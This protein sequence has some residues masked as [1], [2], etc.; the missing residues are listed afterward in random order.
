MAPSTIYL[1]SEHLNIHPSKNPCPRKG[2]LATVPRAALPPVSTSMRHIPGTSTLLVWGLVLWSPCLHTTLGC[3]TMVRAGLRN[4]TNFLESR[5]VVVKRQVV[6]RTCN[7]PGLKHTFSGNSILGKLRRMIW[8]PIPLT[9]PTPASPV[10][11]SYTQS[12]GTQVGHCPAARWEAVSEEGRAG[13]GELEPSR[14]LGS[15]LN[16]KNT[17]TC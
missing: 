7:T 12:P 9:L 13:R 8:K 1:T 15:L 16:R 11:V 10:K 17:F 14:L 5:K 2:R 6:R 4:M 3:C